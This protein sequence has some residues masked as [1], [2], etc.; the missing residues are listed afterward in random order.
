[1]TGTLQTDPKE[2]GNG[3]GEVTVLMTGAGAPGASGIVRSLRAWEDREV[4]IVGVDANSD[5][6][7]FALVDESYTVPHGDDD[8]YIPRMAEIARGE[9][10]DV[11]LPLTTAELG[12]LA[13][14]RDAFDATVMVSEQDALDVANDK[15]AL[16]DFLTEEEFDAAPEFYH[17]QTRTDFLHAVETLG[18]P[19][20][21]VCFKPPVA[22]GMRGFRVLDARGDGLDRLLGEKP[23]AAVTTLEEV[24]P[25]LASA[26]SFPELAVMEYLPGQEY[27]VDVVATGDDVVTAIPRSRSRTRAGITFEGTVEHKSKLIEAASEIARALGLEYNV[28]L[29]FK[30]DGEGAP[31]LIEINPRV[32][33][34]IV[35]CVGAG[36]NL[37]A[38]GVSQALGETPEEPEIDWGTEMVR[39]WQELFRSPEG[40][41]FHVDPEVEGPWTKP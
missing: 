38:M 40:E 14:E 20:Q 16:Y 12:P 17:V 2:D 7:G 27:S 36:A 11:V 41:T 19:E 13:A 24:L 34:T 4:R 30:Y 35:M 23:D 15:A 10:V 21:P 33:G 37:P 3:N 32:A 31:K 8:G 18:Y 5:A 1:M 26:D 39:Y 28:N 25:V 9:D 29:Q 22:S 6:Y